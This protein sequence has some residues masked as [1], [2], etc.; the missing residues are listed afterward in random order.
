MV[1][2][3]LKDEANYGA[4]AEAATVADDGSTI[5]DIHAYV[6]SLIYKII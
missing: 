1:T 3:C 4:E 2:L 6:V 5:H